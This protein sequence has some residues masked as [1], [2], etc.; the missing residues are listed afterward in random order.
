MEKLYRITKNFIISCCTIFLFFNLNNLQ[1]VKDIFLS[2]GV[3]DPIEIQ[4]YLSV[5]IIFIISI[6]FEIINYIF[7]KYLYRPIRVTLTFSSKG[8]N[9][10][11]LSFKKVRDS[12]GANRYKEQ[13]LGIDMFLNEGTP[14]MYLLLNMLDVKLYL[15]YNP[16]FFDT[17]DENGKLITSNDKD[18]I[19]T[20]DRTNQYVCIDLFNGYSDPGDYE[21]DT[22]LFIKPKFSS[23][24]KSSLSIKVRGTNPIATVVAKFCVKLINDSVMLDRQEV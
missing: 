18:K 17:T 20:R 15:K 5:I 14:L 12:T 1:F 10:S 3:T 7:N 16:K 9:I 11:K 23:F 8:K 24:K 19:L 13:L 2:F 4:E 22:K 6:T 21:A